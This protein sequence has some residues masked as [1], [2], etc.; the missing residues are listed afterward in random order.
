MKKM[1]KYTRK[2]RKKINKKNINIMETNEI[3]LKNIKEKAKE[4]TDENKKKMHL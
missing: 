1:K 3:I 4:V 2:L